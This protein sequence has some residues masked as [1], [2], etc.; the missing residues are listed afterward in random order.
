MATTDFTNLITLTDAGWFD[1]AD[2]AAYAY[3]TGTAGTNTITATGS[4]AMSAYAAG[5]KVHFIPA[6]T[7]TGATTI[8]ITQSGASALG[9]K[10][11]FFNG[12]ACVGGE[13]RVNIPIILVYDGT[14]F[15]IIN[16]SRVVSATVAAHAT[17]MNPWVAQV[18]V[19]SGG[20]VTF[21]DI[22]D[23]PYV[24][25]VVWVKMNAAH[26][27][28]DGATFN[29]QGGANYTAAADDWIRIYA[30]T[31]STFEITI[32]KADGTAAVAGSGFTT[33]DVKLTLKTTADSG[34]VLMNDTTIGNGS[35]GASGRANADT[36]D[37]YTLLW[38]NTADAQCA[39]STGR[40]ANAAADYAANKTIALPKALGRALATYG[41]GSGLTS[42]V[43]ALTTGVE[44][45]PLSIAELAAHDHTVTASNTAGS[46]FLAGSGF[47]QTG[48]TGSTGSGTAHQN[49]QPTLFLNTMIKL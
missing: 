6:A 36:V 32:F 31:V 17:T 46:S 33:G 22:A 4:A 43:L 42:R 15:N 27:W 5:Q 14:Q 35:S 37:L 16:E 40:G 23:A 2:K 38:N 44:T 29:V 26:V 24:G 20:A 28:T 45:H 12:A 47:A 18:I 13:I 3:L 25:A 49:M 8:N 21:T 34:W 48:N 7:N 41:A 39:V 19:A 9:A 11:I 10:N 30:T 1:D